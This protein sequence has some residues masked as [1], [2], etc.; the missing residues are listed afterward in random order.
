M[1]LAIVPA[2]PPTR[3]NQ[4]ATSWPAP[5]SAK[6]PYLLESRLM[7]SAFW[8]VSK[9]SRF[10]MPESYGE[11]ATRDESKKGKSEARKEGVAPRQSARRKAQTSIYCCLDS[12]GSDD[13][14][15]CVSV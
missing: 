9:T 11:N 10:V 13:S 7:C 3:K 15:G 12:A 14:V 1:L 6:V 2:A 5:I 4:R 8:C